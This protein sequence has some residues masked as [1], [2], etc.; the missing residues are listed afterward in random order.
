[1]FLS[2][3]LCSQTSCPIRN[4]RESAAVVS[5]P[6]SRRRNNFIHFVPFSVIPPL[7]SRISSSPFLPTHS[8][9]FF[10]SLAHASF[11]THGCIG[12]L[13]FAFSKTSIYIHHTFP[14][15]VCL[16][17]QGT[18]QAFFRQLIFTVSVLDLCLYNTVSAHIHIKVLGSLYYPGAPSHPYVFLC[19]WILRSSSLSSFPCCSLSSSSSSRLPSVFT[20]LPTH[21]NALLSFLSPFFMRGVRVRTRL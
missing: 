19:S 12:V 20:T 21:L 6:V 10:W 9:Q 4:A 2:L 13:R 11:A 8:Y 5:V 7:H 18:P 17:L 15:L 16:S 1:M 3:S 14:K